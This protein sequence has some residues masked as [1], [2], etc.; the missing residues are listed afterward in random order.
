MAS[1]LARLHAT[2]PT[3]VKSNVQDIEVYTGRMDWLICRG[4]PRPR[5]VEPWIDKHV[6]AYK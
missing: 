2:L 4:Q 3:N 6:Y 5:D 1:A